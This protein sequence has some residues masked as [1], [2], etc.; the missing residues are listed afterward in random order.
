MTRFSGCLGAAVVGLMVLVG[1]AALITAVAKNRANQDRVY[2][3]NNL[4]QLAEFAAVPTAGEGAPAPNLSRAGVPPGTVVNPTLS[5]TR[6]L[7]W[8]ADALPA[9]DQN[10]QDAAE[11]FRRIDRAA[12][13]DAGPNAA[14]ART[15][16]GV[17][18]CYGNPPPPDANSPAVSQY[19]GLSG[20]DPGGAETGLGPP[21]PPR[22]GCFRYDEPTPYAA[23]SDGLANTALFGETNRGLGPWL[24]GG[25][26]TV[27][28]LLVGDIAPR[29]VGVGGQYGGNH[30]GVGGFAFADGSV[31]FLSDRIAPAVMGGLMTIAGGT[32]EGTRGE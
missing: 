24:E 27:R 8:V 19:L 28:G 9:V 26:S 30:P 15:R 18:T 12:A 20:L 23:V 21:V 3:T 1:G 25:P 2:C 10:Q 7:S 32:D 17:L 4:R 31:R 29:P 11:L 13:W 5:P 16:L 22:G 14:V 6:R